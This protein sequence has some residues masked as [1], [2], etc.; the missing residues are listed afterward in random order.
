MR[1][2]KNANLIDK[3]TDACL[4]LFDTDTGRMMELN[5]TARL[6]WKKTGGSFGIGNLKK[7]IREYCTPVGD[8]D[9]DL[10]E[11]VKNAVKYGLVSEV[12][13]D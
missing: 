12:G 3:E 2:L 11:F 1:Y 8:C 6:L 5:T 9:A 13:Q 4:L 7:I 10:S